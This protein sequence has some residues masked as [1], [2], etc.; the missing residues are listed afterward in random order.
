MGV[1]SEAGRC[2]S[3]ASTMQFAIMVARIMYS[4]G[5]KMLRNFHGKHTQRFIDMQTHS[6]HNTEPFP[7]RN[8]E[9]KSLCSLLNVILL[10]ACLF[11]VT[12]MQL[13][14][15]APPAA[16]MKHQGCEPAQRCHHEVHE[17]TNSLMSYSQSP[18]TVSQPH[19]ACCDR[20]TGDN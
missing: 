8:G 16:C 9:Q 20:Q 1:L 14:P 13:A 17:A 7:M 12:P 6:H 3:R 5:V 10:T 19:G 11:G 2:C 15:T 4:N 18:A